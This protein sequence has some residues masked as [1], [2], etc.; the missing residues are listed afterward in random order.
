MLLDSEGIPIVSDA[1]GDTGHSKND[2]TAPRFKSEVLGFS[3]TS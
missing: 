2:R 1:D 3:D